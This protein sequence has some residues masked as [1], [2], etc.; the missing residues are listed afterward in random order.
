MLQFLIHTG[1]ER[2]GKTNGTTEFSGRRYPERKR[3]RISQVRPF[4]THF[5]GLVMLPTGSTSVPLQQLQVSHH[6]SI[7]MP[8]FEA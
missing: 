8:V 6:T 3:V 4:H 1:L 7:S 5:A 2:T